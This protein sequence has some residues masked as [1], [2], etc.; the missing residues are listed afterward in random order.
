MSK[1]DAKLSFDKNDRE[2][3]AKY[4]MEEIINKENDWNHM[5]EAKLVEEFIEKIAC[6]EIVRAMKP[7]KIAR[8][9]EVCAEM[10]SASIEVGINICLVL[11]LCH[12]GLNG[13]GKLSAGQTSMLVP[14]FKEKGDFRNCYAYRRVK[15]SVHNMKI[16]EKVLKR[17]VWKLV[18]IDAMQLGFKPNKGTIDALFGAIRK[19][20]EY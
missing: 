7:G 11:E 2:R 19:P 1:K 3:M 10:I 17:R 20:E 4:H 8:P 13:K 14:I 9:Y 16:V 12:R 18:N 5:K 15:L 6:E